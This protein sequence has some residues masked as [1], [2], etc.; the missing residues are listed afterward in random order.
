MKKIIKLGILSILL[1]TISVQAL[2]YKT[3]DLITKNVEATVTGDSFRYKEFSYQERNQTISFTIKNEM[4]E[5]LPISI[6]VGFFTDKEKNIGTLYYCDQESILEKGE[7][8]E[9]SIPIDSKDFNAEEVKY[10]SILSE[11]RGCYHDFSKEDV[12]KTVKQIF[13]TKE[14]VITK[15]VSLFIKVLEV[16]LGIIVIWLV[17][18][19]AFTNSFE[20]FDGNDVR[21]GYRNFEKKKRKEKQKEEKRKEN[22]EVKEASQSA[23]EER[24]YEQEQEAKNED[25]SGTDLH[26]LY[27]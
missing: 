6:S 27:K 11:N 8:K 23:K 24:I 13:T 14:D 25:K 4:T 18:R 3:R 9:V 7:E 21:R 20:N 22:Q 5:I 26:N 10:V 1:L 16:T 19:F 12:G 17:Y 2:N 15:D